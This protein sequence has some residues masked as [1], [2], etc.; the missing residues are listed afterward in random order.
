[1]PADQRVL[2]LGI[3]AAERGR[4][5]ALISRLGYIAILAEDAAAAR[6]DLEREEFPI[7]IIDMPDRQ[8]QI[9]ELRA[10]IPG[11]SFLAIGARTLAAGLAAW[12]AGVDGY[13]PR[14][15]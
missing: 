13:L 14:P 6:A 4:L 9:A 3:R 11:S 1:M 5:A 8:A 7:V 15:L 10:Q 2:L 12:Y